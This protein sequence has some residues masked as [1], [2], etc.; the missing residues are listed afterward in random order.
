MSLLAPISMLK[1]YCK[2]NKCPG[3]RTSAG[4][5][6]GT[7]LSTTS[8]PLQSSSRANQ[9]RR[10]SSDHKSSAKFHRSSVKA[11]SAR[12]YLCISLTNWSSCISRG[13]LYKDRASDRVRKRL[14]T[15]PGVTFPL[16]STL[17]LYNAS[18]IC[19]IFLV[20]TNYAFILTQ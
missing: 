7:P 2:K 16:V 10:P 20:I 8:V 12:M 3:R 6:V 15:F 14:F 13:Q 5:F 1:K 19:R 18:T 17:T 11:A 9:I 4:P